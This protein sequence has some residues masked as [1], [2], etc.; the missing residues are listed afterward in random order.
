M[1]FWVASLQRLQQPVKANAFTMV[2]ALNQAQVM[3]QALEDES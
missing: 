1:R 3:R 2:V